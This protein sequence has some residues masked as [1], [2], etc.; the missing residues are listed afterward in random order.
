MNERAKKMY[1]APPPVRLG[2]VSGNSVLSQPISEY[3]TYSG[4]WVI[5]A[6]NIMVDSMNANKN[7]L[8]KNLHRANPNATNVA[9]SGTATALN[10][11]ISMVCNSAL[12]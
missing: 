11:M 10:T 5:T 4:I 9:E 3:S 12:P 8:P 7:F 1:N 2:M 6:G